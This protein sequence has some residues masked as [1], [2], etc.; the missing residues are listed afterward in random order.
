MQWVVLIAAVVAALDQLTKWLVVRCIGPEESRVVI[1]GFFNLVNWH[2]TGAA[3][4]I[5][6]DYNLVLTVISALTVL[7][8]Y[9]FRHTFQLH[10][11][12]ARVALGLITGGIIGNLI[13]RV[14]VQHVIDFLYFYIGRYHWPAFNVADSAICVGVSLYII[15]TWRSERQAAAHRGGTQ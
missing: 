3:W 10:R 15:V 13:D 5:L 1:P 2:N 14:R 11:P 9:F 7:A 8:L 6:Q 4:G 12:G